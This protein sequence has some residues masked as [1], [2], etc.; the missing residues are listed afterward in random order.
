M[1]LYQIRNLKTIIT[2]IDEICD[3]YN[4]DDLS[5]LDKEKMKLFLQNILNTEHQLTTTDSKTYKR[6]YKKV[7]EGFLPK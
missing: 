1:S 5:V 7:I 4:D 6:Y 2:K 3:L